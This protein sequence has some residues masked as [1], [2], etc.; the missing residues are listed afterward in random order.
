MKIASVF[1]SMPGN[2][3]G[4]ISI[5][6][7]VSETLKDLGI[8]PEEINLGYRS[9]PYYDGIKSEYMNTIA[10]M[11]RTSNGIIFYVSASFGL[12]GALAQT[13]IEHF[14]YPEYAGIMNDKNCF[15]VM[16][17]DDNTGA[18]AISAMDLAIYNMGAF[19]GARVLVDKGFTDKLEQG[20]KNFVLIER[21]C[22]DYY[23]ALRQQRT[24][25]R[26]GGTMMQAQAVKE[27]P[28]RKS[29]SNDEIKYDE[30]AHHEMFGQNVQTSVYEQ[31]PTRRTSVYEPN[32]AEQ[33]PVYE[34]NPAEPIPAYEQRIAADTLP[35]DS[36]TRSQ[37]NDIDEISKFFAKKFQLD[38]AA[39]LVSKEMVPIPSTRS[40]QKTTLAQKTSSLT[41]YFKSG[42]AEG[43]KAV[44]SLSISGK[45]AFEGYIE[46]NGPDCDFNM[47]Q[48][49]AADVSIIAEGAKWGEIIRGKTSAQKA[50]MIGQIKVRGNFVLLSRFDQLFD[51]GRN[52]D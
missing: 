16:N 31:Q 30:K 29:I 26:P 25:Y 27:M 50:F 9:L 28:V 38:D 2:Q 35:T 42:Q 33:V 19:S 24:M 51:F 32:L 11:I 34:P 6:N 41:H 15:I 36:F 8:E 39:N 21:L 12:P 17:C 49:S 5:K 45:D 43:L 20:S 44:I 37:Q 13:L 7:I 18:A 52:S 4:L 48:P 47:G 14:S 46:I 10:D 3:S 40:A 22:E 1:A 23:R